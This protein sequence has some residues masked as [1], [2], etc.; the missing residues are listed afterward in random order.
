VHRLSN[1][2]VGEDRGWG[3]DCWRSRHDRHRRHSDRRYDPS[4][5]LSD[6]RNN[7]G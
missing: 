1:L 2:V 6:R 7:Q 4:I 5:A 3:R